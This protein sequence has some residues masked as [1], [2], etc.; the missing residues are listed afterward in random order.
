MTELEDNSLDILGVK[1]IAKSVDKSFDLSIYFKVFS[2]YLR[3]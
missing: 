3:N 1:P 2:I